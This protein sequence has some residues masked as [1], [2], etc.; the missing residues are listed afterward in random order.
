MPLMLHATITPVNVGTIVSGMWRRYVAT[1]AFSSFLRW[2]PAIVSTMPPQIV[3]VAGPCIR[4]MN[5][6]ASDVLR[7]G[8]RISPFIALCASSN[9]WR[10]SS[11]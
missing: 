4:P 11:S 3:T 7:L 9:R 1:A 6:Q 10:R 2:S 5:M 8:S